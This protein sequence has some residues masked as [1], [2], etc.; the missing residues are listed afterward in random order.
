MS[1]FVLAISIS[2]PLFNG[3]S[4]YIS[5]NSLQTA[6]ATV[7]LRL[8][9]NSNS[10]D[11]LFL[12]NGQI[13][14]GPDYIAIAL[15]S[16][17]VELLFNLG[18]GYTKVISSK[19]ITMNEWHTIEVQR[20]G[21]QAILIVDESLPV[22]NTSSQ[23]SMLNLGDSLY[24]GGVKD[25][26]QLPSELV[27]VPGFN[28]C[29]RNLSY[30]SNP[31]DLIGSA[32]D[33]AMIG[34]CSDALECLNQ[35]CNNGGTCTDHD[36]NGSYSCTCAVGYTDQ[37]CDT[38]ITE[39]SD[40]NMCSNGG[41]CVPEVVNNTLVD[42]CVCSL[43]HGGPTCADGKEH[44]YVINVH[45]LHNIFTFQ[46]F[47]SPMLRLALTVTYSYQ[48]IQYRSIRES[49]LTVMY[50]VIVIILLYIQDGDIF[51]DKV[52]NHSNSFRWSH[53]VH[54]KGE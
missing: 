15:R 5:Y 27:L 28:G 16:N 26:S 10:S 17:K 48:L 18:F 50:R 11:G 40:P 37:T 22:V 38:A 31:M 51:F 9:V 19:M 43:P 44:C 45:Y 30:N 29:I 39:C 33:G 12:Y 8:E 24:I 49:I 21:P 2:T 47:P 20:T 7:E 34:E 46:K 52:H 32:I 6:Y 13:N 3:V 42:T 41:D 53:N 1:V 23:G 36:F 54:R 4:S 25:Y 14:N 35:P